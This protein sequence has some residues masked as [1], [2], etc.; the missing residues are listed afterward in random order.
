MAIIPV[1]ARLLAPWRS[2]EASAFRPAP[3]HLEIAEARI[4]LEHPLTR[5]CGRA[6]LL[7]SRAA[8]V[9]ATASIAALL[10]PSAAGP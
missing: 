9:A 3:V 5:R 6:V 8:P 2:A 1:L 4:N 7:G 10:R